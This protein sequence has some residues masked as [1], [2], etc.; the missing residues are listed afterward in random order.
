MLNIIY[1]ATFLTNVFKKDQSRSGIF[2]V[3]W[4]V[5]E[6][7]RNRSDVSLSLYFDPEHYAGG[8]RF[9]R[10][11]APEL[12]YAQNLSKHSLLCKLNL[13][14]WSIHARIF[15]HRY[16]RLPFALG[17]LLSQKLLSFLTK[18]EIKRTVVDNS[19]VFFSPANGTPS[20]IRHNKNLKSFVILHDAIPFLFP[21]IN[22]A[23]WFLQKVIDSAKIED[24]F[25]CVSKNTQND[26]CK[27]FPVV[28][29]LNSRVVNLAADE[30]FSS[31][32]QNFEL[33]NLRKKYG[34]PKGKKYVFSLCTL[35]PRKNLVRAVRSF[36]KFVE[37]NQIENLIWVMGGGAWKSFFEK[38]KS[39]NVSWNPD[40]ICRIGYVDD[41][42]LPILYRNAEWFVY[43]SQ[44]EGFGL[45]SLEAMQCGCPVIV[46]NN[47]SLPEVVGDAGILIDWDSDEQHIAAYEKYYFD[48]GYRNTKAVEGLERAKLFSWKKTVDQMVDVMKRC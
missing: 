45:P 24:C 46:S 37:K 29:P 23:D 30:K 35:E 41:I 31:S 33:D 14:C 10:D 43:T 40:L 34:I 5:F 44:Y 6:Q 8:F 42:D 18:K 7:L 15:H 22:C 32:S 47:S 13:K 25:F 28:T 39:Q 4:N 17:I 2:F 1:D 48:R 3:A 27:L 11:V 19:N 38:L 9:K 16:F 26:F 36:V 20:L 21:E 12:N